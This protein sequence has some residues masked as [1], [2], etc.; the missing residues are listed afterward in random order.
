MADEVDGPAYFGDEG[1]TECLVPYKPKV[2]AR[3]DNP[4]L[5]QLL[6]NIYA[7]R[8]EFPSDHP[9]VRFIQKAVEKIVGRIA[10]ELDKY[11]QTL[12]STAD[13][14]IAALVVNKPSCNIS[15]LEEE[16]GKNLFKL[17]SFYERTK[18]TFPDEFDFVYVPY[19]LTKNPDGLDPFFELKDEAFRK[20]VSY[21]SNAGSLM[22]RNEDIGDVF[23]EKYEG[24]S[25]IAA[26]FQF[27]FIRDVRFYR[28]GKALKRTIRVNLIPGILVIDPNL[29]DNIETLCPIPG[30]RKEVLETSPDGYL[31]LPNSFTAFCESE[32]HFMNHVLSRRHV[33][34]YRVL[35]YLLHGQKSGE[36]LEE[37]CKKSKHQIMCS[38][39]SYAIK[40][41]MIRHHYDCRDGSDKL[42]ACAL[43]VLNMF[44][45]SYLYPVAKF[46][47]DA[48]A[49]QVQIAT[50]TNRPLTI[51]YGDE[52]FIQAS[53]RC[54]NYMT[55]YLRRYRKT[56]ATDVNLDPFSLRMI[57]VVER[58]NN[59]HGSKLRQCKRDV[60]GDFGSDTVGRFCYKI[61]LFM[62]IIGFCSALLYIMVKKTS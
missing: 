39:P 36:E 18:N 5:E 51:A 61:V 52:E 29:Q 60:F 35:K 13:K 2:K 16:T 24:Q 32:V 6:Q 62:I 56:S 22:Y 8:L 34:V 38:I 41:A 33:A 57:T 45:Q 55:R 21:L 11:K 40:T 30:F 58:Y 44:E 14:S 50:P 17:G 47:E 54:L 49:L 42:G 37:A 28:K 27:A 15:D 20:R 4:D 26:E 10:K 43:A 59:N 31:L 25:D 19:R 53:Y 12:F 1:E 7:R 3:F 46:G 9:E 48:E 23:F